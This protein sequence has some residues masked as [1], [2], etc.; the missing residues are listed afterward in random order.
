MIRLSTFVFILTAAAATSAVACPEGTPPTVE[1][2]DNYVYIPPDECSKPEPEV[3]GG[4]S[5]PQWGS[6][7]GQRREIAL[8]PNHGAIPFDPRQDIIVVDDPDFGKA[9][10]ES[11]E[12]ERD[13]DYF[14]ISPIEEPRDRF[15]T[16]WRSIIDDK[17]Y[18]HPANGW[19]TW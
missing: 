2:G 11:T 16:P 8:P 9:P 15:D 12:P 13:D 5:L 17:Y 14:Y 4:F 3:G 18:A 1:M 6:L 7:P 19:T 10:G